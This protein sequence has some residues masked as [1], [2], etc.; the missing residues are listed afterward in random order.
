MDNLM[1]NIMANICK[2]YTL[3]LPNAFFSL[4]LHVL[5]FSWL[6]FSESLS[7]ESDGKG[8]AEQRVTC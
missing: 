6:G 1:T 3:T 8:K 2:K 4:G 5:C 7:Y